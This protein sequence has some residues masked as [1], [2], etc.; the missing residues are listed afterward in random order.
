MSHRRTWGK[1]FTVVE[2]LVVISIIGV[3]MAL[4]LPAVQAARETARRMQCSSNLRQ[5]GIAVVNF[6]T[7]K[8]HLPPARSFPV[9]SPTVYAKPQNWN[10]TGAFPEQVVS[11]VYFI[12]PN[13]EQGDLKTTMDKQF[14]QA[15]I[16]ITTMHQSA[17]IAVRPLH[18][19]SDQTDRAPMHVSYACNGGLSDDTSPA[20]N[21]PF[22]W[23][24]N[25]VFLTRLKGTNDTHKI[26]QQS[27]GDIASADGNSNTIMLAE[28]H[29]LDLWHN[30]TSEY[31]ASIVWQE[32]PTSIGGQLGIDLTMGYGPMLDEDHAHPSSLHPGGFMVVMCDGSTKFIADSVDYTVYARLMTSN[33]KKYKSAGQSTAIGAVQT[34]QQTPLSADSY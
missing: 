6:D 25:G 34:I 24:A 15:G 33:G 28:N 13:I 20:N 16:D 26:E 9:L 1:G 5:L 22:D 18:C 2:M 27:L 31:S 10:Q 7:T 11:W 19:P 23:A 21:N 3:M 4:L 30:A 17:P 8:Q 14:L 12:L 32:S 29:Y